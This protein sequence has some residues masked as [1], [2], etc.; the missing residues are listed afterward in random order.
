MQEQIEQF[1]DAMREAGVGPAS[2]VT[3]EADDTP[4]YYQLDGDKKGKLRGSYCVKVEADGFGA[5]W[6][7]DHRNGISH[8]WH[9]KAKRGISQEEKDAHK[10]KIAEA[11]RKREADIK[12]QHEEAAERARAI[13]NE[14][15]R[16]GTT[17]YLGRKRIGLNG[18]RIHK[19]MVAVPMYKGGA[20]IGLQFIGPDGVKKFLSGSDKTGSY[21]SMRGADMGVIRVCEGFATGCAIRA[22]YP[23]N[24]VIVAW[25]A[26]NLKPVCAAMASKYPDSRIIICGD[27]DQWTT[28]HKG[29]P[30]NPGL[31]KAMQAAVSIGGSMVVVPPFD[32]D[33]EGRRTDW[34]DYW[35][36][37]GADAARIA[38]DTPYVE[39]EE[40][41]TPLDDVV[42]DFDV[43]D[44]DPPHLDQIRPLGIGEDDYY[45]FFPR[46]VGR[47]VRIAPSNMSKMTG[48]LFRLVS[49]RNFWEMHY[50]VDG[51]GSSSA[52]AENA[53][54]HLMSVCHRK[55]VFREDGTRG[56]GVWEDDN[57][58]VVNTGKRIIGYGIDVS[59]SDFDSEHVYQSGISV[60]DMKVKAL[61]D[62]EAK[63]LL[64]LCLMLSWKRSE[65]GYLLSGWS[66]C[67]GVG[68]A[69]DWRPHIWLT[70]PSGSG[71][72]T[73]MDKIIKAV[74]RRIAVIFDGGT[75]EAGVRKY[76]GTSSRPFV[77]DEAES[78]TARDRAEM[79]KIVGL[80]RKAS[81]GGII[82][83][84][85][86]TF[87]ARS[88]ACFAAINPNVKEVADQARITLLELERDRSPNSREKYKA[89]LTEI[90][91]LIGKDFDKRL[92][93]F[94]FDNIDTLTHN[95]RSFNAAA[96]AEFGNQRTADQ[97]AP[98]IAGAHLL[99]GVKKISVDE[100]AAWLSDGDWDWFT[101]IADES[102]S[103]KLF[104]HIMS[105]R[106]E[107]DVMGGM[108]RRGVIGDMIDSI[109]MG[110]EGCDDMHRGL[111][112]YGIKVDDG[113][114]YI[115]NSNKNLAGLL[116]DTP[117]VPW[118]RTLGD[119][120]DS[121][122]NGN[123]A[124]S[125]LRGVVSKVKTIPVGALGEVAVDD[126]ASDDGYIMEGF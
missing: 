41:E 42:G 108:S 29:D 119:F 34:W 6:F 126:G 4:H 99:S 27:N 106:I 56:V 18:A 89:I 10:A 25:D 58:Y 96:S 49:N 23:D 59:P 84:A 44:G 79:D 26:G 62:D 82:A 19:D 3:I 37:Y 48:G 9:T 78:E 105:S 102:D 35:D 109:V 63:R 47:I 38:M 81:S 65:Y 115:A 51:K 50:D 73:V 60:I 118:A 28:N 14:C 55:G 21:H 75:S 97:L 86:S 8:P 95:I 93:K 120:P 36:A 1:V 103:G 32:S 76:L 104:A 80:F 98:M 70:G 101:S 91:D 71:K 11:K 39:R 15:A 46:E 110:V 53:S 64:D 74:L 72:S 114:I 68:G 83:N 61:T 7:Y 123:R 111:K 122:N 92:F 117:W 69:F 67:A 88:C 124:V 12:R 125:F 100:A 87:N 116:R 2:G 24:P 85:N 66:V 13:W 33:D 43:D 121:G 112:A 54:A 20:I 22:C 94:A 52:I 30:W 16:E 45:I 77:M 40:V 113:M 107:Y 31:E 90:N 5:G 17:E 57:G